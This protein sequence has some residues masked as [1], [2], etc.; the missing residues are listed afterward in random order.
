MQPWERLQ[1]EFLAFISTILPWFSFLIN[2]REKKKKNEKTA[3]LLAKLQLW[4]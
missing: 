3:T 1:P 2:N 4:G